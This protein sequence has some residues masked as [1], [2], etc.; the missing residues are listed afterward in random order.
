MP[1]VKVDINDV[2]LE[3]SHCI[4]ALLLKLFLGFIQS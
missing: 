1:I 4:L 2:L 3:M